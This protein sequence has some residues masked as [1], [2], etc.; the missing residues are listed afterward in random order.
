MHEWALAEGVIKTA[1]EAGEKEGLRSITR[2]SVKIGELQRIKK[3][4]FENALQT[5]MPETDPR[6]AATRITLEIEQARF[7]CRPC[8]AEFLLAD[9]DGPVDHAQ[10]ESIH[11][12]PELAHAFMSCPKCQSPDFE[13]IEGRGVWIDAVEGE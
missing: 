13:V 11:F 6:L 12:I 3:D 9:L 4:V 5:V 1:L 2:I 7:R 10:L 8:H